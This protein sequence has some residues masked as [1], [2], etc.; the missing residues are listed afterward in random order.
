MRT[1]YA[2]RGVSHRRDMVVSSK[3][4]LSRLGRGL[5]IRYSQQILLTVDKGTRPNS[6]VIDRPS[7][8]FRGRLNLAHESHPPCEQVVDDCVHQSHGA[9]SLSTANCQRTASQ[10][11]RDSTPCRDPQTNRSSTSRDK[12][13]ER[14]G[15]A[16]S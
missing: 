7:L 13:R 8:A 5:F 4:M 6:P 16:A 3:N 9:T 10:R 12:R 11:A 14:A 1:S 15:T 2:Q